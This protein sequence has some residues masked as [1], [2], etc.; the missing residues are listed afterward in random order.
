MDTGVGRDRGVRGA[1]GAGDTQE[2][3][4]REGGEDGLV[5]ELDVED[6]LGEQRLSESMV[7]HEFVYV[8]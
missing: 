2:V 4:G 6:P 1:A 8:A 7:S 3:G 5:Y